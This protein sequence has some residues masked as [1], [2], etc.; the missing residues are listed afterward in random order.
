MIGPRSFRL[1]CELQQSYGLE[2]ENVHLCRLDV[3]IFHSSL[4]TRISGMAP[5]LV[6]WDYQLDSAYPS[7]R[8]AYSSQAATLFRSSDQMYRLDLA[9][10]KS[11]RSVAARSDPFTAACD[12]SLCQMRA[13]MGSSSE[14]T[15]SGVPDALGLG[16]RSPTESPRAA[17]ARHYKTGRWSCADTAS[18]GRFFQR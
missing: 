1:N 8:R 11:G 15:A 3:A 12:A 18:P 4:N 14:G 16:A 17:H 13:T 2:C 7:G 6:C 5:K 9:T 10:I